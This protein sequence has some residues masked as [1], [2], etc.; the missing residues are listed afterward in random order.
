MRKATI[1]KFVLSLAVAGAVASPAARAQIVI[2]MSRVTCADYLAMTPEQ[3]RVFSAWMSG[4]FNQKT[5]Y[6]WID[7]GAYARNIANITQWCASYPQE[8]V[9]TGLERS[10]GQQ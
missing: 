7:F 4:Y 2:D 9:M 6:T 1:S 5:G 8:K 10:T 3:S